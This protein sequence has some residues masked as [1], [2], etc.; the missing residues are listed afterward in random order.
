ML[1]GCAGPA[2]TPDARASASSTPRTTATNTVRLVAF[3]LQAQG[4]TAH[5]DVTINVGPTSYE[6]RVR[7]SAL[8]PGAQYLINLHNGSCA[9]EDTSFLLNLGRFEA[10]ASGNAVYTQTFPGLFVVSAAGRIVTLHGPLDTDDAFVHIACGD[11]P[12]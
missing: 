10:D 2:S 11:M 6:M 8:K 4:R 1:A 7:M 9:A 3:P 12:R 5:G